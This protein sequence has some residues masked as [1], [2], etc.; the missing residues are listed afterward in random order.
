MISQTSR[1]KWLTSYET[2]RIALMGDLPCAVCSLITA[3]CNPLGYKLCGTR[4]AHRTGPTAETTL[5]DQT[6][7]LGD[8]CA[9]ARQRHHRT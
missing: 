2:T 4:L 3:V 9:E 6:V 1:T 7:Y 8:L 5:A